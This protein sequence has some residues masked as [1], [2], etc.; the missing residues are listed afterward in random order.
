[1]TATTDTTRDRIDD[2]LVRL[3]PAQVTVAV[4]TIAALGFVLLFAQEPMVHDSLHT[5]RHA[6]GITCH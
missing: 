3:T 5:F 2:A 6:A 1:M 4:L